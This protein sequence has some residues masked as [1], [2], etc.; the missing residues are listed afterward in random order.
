MQLEALQFYTDESRDNFAYCLFLIL[1]VAMPFCAKLH[2]SVS[3]EVNGINEGHWPEHIQLYIA[4]DVAL[5][6]SVAFPALAFL[7]GF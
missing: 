4:K 5:P 1:T 7:G 6:A 3:I 2:P